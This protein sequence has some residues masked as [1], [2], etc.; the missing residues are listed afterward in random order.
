MARRRAQPGF[1][2]LSFPTLPIAV[3]GERPPAYG[4]NDPGNLRAQCEAV[5]QAPLGSKLTLTD[6]ATGETRTV[7]VTNGRKKRAMQYLQESPAPA[8]PSL[9][10]VGSMGFSGGLIDNLRF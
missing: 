3:P 9:S 7:K 5:L 8:G 10:G 1:P 4:G 6:P 2:T